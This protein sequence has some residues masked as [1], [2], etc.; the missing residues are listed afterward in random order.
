MRRKILLEHIVDS[1]TDLKP[2]LR[3]LTPRKQVESVLGILNLL[4]KPFMTGQKLSAAQKSSEHEIIFH[5]E[6]LVRWLSGKTTVHKIAETF[7]KHLDRT[8]LD[9]PCELLP[10]KPGDV[11][12]LEL[13]ES[14]VFENKGDYFYSAIVMIGS[15]DP[16]AKQGWVNTDDK[17]ATEG[18]CRMLSILAPDC[19]A[20][21]NYKGSSSY[22]I[23][24]IPDGKTLG[25][26]LSTYFDGQDVVVGRHLAM[27]LGKCLL[28]LTSGDPDLRSEAGSYSTSKK[29]KKVRAHNRNF[30]RFDV[31]AVGYG[32]HERIRHVGEAQV[33]GHFRWQRHGIGFS[34]VKLIWIDE[35]ARHYQKTNTA[36]QPSL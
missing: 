18:L 36:G 15:Y 8:D 9:V 2:E 35:H 3:L 4:V 12:M 19:D 33:S 17:A 34:L 23:F 30:C 26:A 6:A 10:C 28:Y 7:G 27:F 1:I 14:I 21:G 16:G 22:T 13:P 29:E 24:P 5:R 25:E 20:E 31:T 11:F 32:F